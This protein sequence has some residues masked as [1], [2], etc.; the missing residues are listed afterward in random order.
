MDRP[1]HNDL[2]G[3]I[4]KLVGGTPNSVTNIEIMDGQE[5]YQ[6]SAAHYTFRYVTPED[7][8]GF[9]RLIEGEVFSDAIIV[10]DNSIGEFERQ[11]TLHGDYVDDETSRRI[12]RI[13]LFGYLSDDPGGPDQLQLPLI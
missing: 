8:E 2:V 13:A 12:V 6:G 9:S 7:E 4:D 1:A 5:L 3:R 11:D 10:K